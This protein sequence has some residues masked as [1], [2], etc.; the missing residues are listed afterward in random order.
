M[1]VLFTRTFMPL[2]VLVL[3]LAL[4]LPV[5]QFIWVIYVRR[6]MRQGDVDE[7]QRQRL[8]RRAGATSALL[9]FVFSYLYASHLFQDAP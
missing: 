1:D 8:K 2:W 4:F 6:A 5:R 7:E 3:A 9:S